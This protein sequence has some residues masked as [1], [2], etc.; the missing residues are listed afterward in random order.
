M[1]SSAKVGPFAQS[2]G[3]LAP[4]ILVTLAAYQAADPNALLDA[5]VQ[6]CNWCVD[7]AWLVRDEV[8]PD[9]WSIYHASYYVAQVN[10]GGHGQFAANSAMKSAVLGDVE[11]GLD[12][13]GLDGLLTIFRRFRNALECDAALKTATMQAAGFGE[14]P[15]AV[16]ELDDAFFDSPDP[17]HFPRQ[18]SRWLKHASTVLALTPRDLRARQTMILA[19]NSLLDR[20][21][22]ASARR[23]PWQRFT[24]AAA[25]AWGRIGLPHS[26]ETALDRA[27][28]QIAANPPPE[29]QMSETRGQLIDA[30]VPAVQDNDNARVDQVLAGFR[31]LHARY[32]LETTSRWPDEIRMYASKLLYAGERLGRADL[33]EQ[34]A[35]AFRRTIATGSTYSYD[36]GFDWRSLGQALVEL[37][38]LD[39]TR[40]RDLSEAVD[41]FVNALMMDAEKPDLYSCRVRSILGRAEAHL[42]HAATDGGAGHLDAAREALAEAR[43]LL[44]KDDRNRWEVVQ[45]QLLSLQLGPKVGTRDRARAARQLDIAIAWETDNAGDARANAIRLERLHQLR[46]AFE[47]T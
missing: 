28:R 33:L 26:E 4:E 31:D 3:L 16:R 39:Q 34:A 32:A 15:L 41:A 27:R 6:F 9:A 13:L 2:Q 11:T 22:S 19:S 44:R 17:G 30:V 23:S 14:I 45:A 37:A 47:D 35:D 40:A 24:E 46:A 38:R 1:M 25:R 5:L 12:R 29:W 7:D 43:P 18:A 20:R 36:P 21:R 8:Q 42:V 10:N